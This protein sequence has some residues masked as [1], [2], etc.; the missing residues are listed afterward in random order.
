MKPWIKLW[1]E[2]LLSS[3][4][5][6]SLF[7]NEKALYLLLYFYARDDS[8]AGGI[9]YPDG[10]PIPLKNLTK[11]LAG[12]LDEVKRIINKLIERRLL[13]YDRNKVLC[14]RNYAKLTINHNLPESP[15]LP[16]ESQQPNNN[17][18]IPLHSTPL[19]SLNLLKRPPIDKDKD[20]DKEKTIAQNDTNFVLFWTAY[21]KKLGKK[22]ALLRWKHLAREKDF[23][24]ITV[25]LILA[26]I[27][28]QKQSEQWQKDGGKFIPHPATWLNGDRWEDEVKQ[29][30]DW[31]NG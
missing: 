19:N 28:K 17:C 27:Q 7:L 10:Q 3:L 8:Y 24:S 1:K 22:K 23:V 30:E 18:T 13:Y 9:C 16:I 2:K 11:I 4:N 6:Q 5:Y 26:A 20:K 15:E 31:R 29:K 25:P 14:I 12:R 21:P